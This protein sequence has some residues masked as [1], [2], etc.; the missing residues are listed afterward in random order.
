MLI[1]IILTSILLIP[2]GLI[3][4]VNLPKFTYEEAANK[5]K[6]YEAQSGK[7][8]QLHLPTHREDKLGLG[9]KSFFKTT[10]HT[11][12]IYLKVE[13]DTVVYKFNPLDGSFEKHSG[14]RTLNSD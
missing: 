1:T 8:V 12:Y 3:Y 9:E 4:Y 6:D 13:N 14:D 5:V 11:Y 2:V 10:N 7:S